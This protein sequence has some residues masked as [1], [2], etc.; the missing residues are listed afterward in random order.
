MRKRIVGSLMLA[1]DVPAWLVAKLS[2]SILLMGCVL[3]APIASASVLDAVSVGDMFSGVITLNPSAA[4]TSSSNSFLGGGE[5]SVE[6]YYGSVGGM[7]TFQIDGTTLSFP[8]V[9]VLTENNNFGGY[10]VWEAF[11]GATIPFSPD[12]VGIRIGI[13]SFD[14]ITSVLPP[15]P[16][17]TCIGAVCLTY[18]GLSGYR[19][20]GDAILADA[21]AT[22]FT[23]TD[24]GAI[25]SGSI[26]GVHV[27]ATP[28]LS[29]WA[30]LLIGFAGIGITASRRQRAKSALA[31]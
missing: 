7:L 12:S 17:N 3:H 24:T 6:S 27:S 18:F 31:R 30:M 1:S 25:F 2:I 26:T 14:A 10:N 19:S 13:D 9:S 11:S 22:S 5:V 15:V 29:T 8:L 20:N 23:L 28:E 21:E 4:L 16:Y